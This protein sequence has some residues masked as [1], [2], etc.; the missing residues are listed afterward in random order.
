VNAEELRKYL[1]Q[2]AHRHI[3]TD[4]DSELLLNI[5]ANNL[6]KIGKFRINE[7][8]IF[9]AIKGVYDVCHG[10]YACVAMIAGELLFGLVSVSLFSFERAKS[11][12]DREVE[13]LLTLSFLLKHDSVSLG[14]VILTAFAPLDS[15][16]AHHPW[17]PTTCLLRR[18]LCVMAA[19]SRTL[20]TLSRARL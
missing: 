7:E 12:K 8:D 3:N 16:G 18:V 1:D 20:R 13:N 11:K 2:D 6:Q 17:E 14:S 9:I 19:V 5:F 4:S 15:L 10:G